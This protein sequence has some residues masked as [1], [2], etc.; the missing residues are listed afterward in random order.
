MARDGF[1]AG[2]YHANLW[3]GPVFMGHEFLS[4]L[5]S[6]WANLWSAGRAFEV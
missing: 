5:I 6:A 4:L 1:L 3:R 2:K